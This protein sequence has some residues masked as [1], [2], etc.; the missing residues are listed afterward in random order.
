MMEKQLELYDVQAGSEKGKCKV[1]LRLRDEEGKKLVAPLTCH[2]NYM[3]SIQ[4]AFSR[5]IPI[6]IEVKEDPPVKVKRE[7]RG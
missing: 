2:T 3:E 4:K 1:F 7:K 5:M 6:K